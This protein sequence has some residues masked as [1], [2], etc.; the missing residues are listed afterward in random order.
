MDSILELEHEP[1]YGSEGTGYWPHLAGYHILPIPLARKQM[2]LGDF[3]ADP[4]GFAKQSPIERLNEHKF[5]FE[6]GE[7]E[8][9]DT[10]SYTYSWS[11]IRDG[12]PKEDAFQMP[13]FKTIKLVNV[14]EASCLKAI[15]ASSVWDW[16]C[17]NNGQ[18]MYRV[19][20]LKVALRDGYYSQKYGG[21]P[22]RMQTDK[23]GKVF[24]V[25]LVEISCTAPGSDG[26]MVLTLKEYQDGDFFCNPFVLPENYASLI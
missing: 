6:E 14:T 8:S 4:E 11:E 5:T 21:G 23:V 22:I 3:I 15:E 2:R 18:S 13:H 7:R 1:I 10:E 19:V 12:V 20:G 24:A 17:K 9:Y 26:A 16:L 25:R